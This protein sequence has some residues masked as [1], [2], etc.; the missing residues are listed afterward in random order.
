MINENQRYVTGELKSAFYSQPNQ[1]GATGL[2]SKSSSIGS[3]ISL[4][5]ATTKGSGLGPELLSIQNTKTFAQEAAP[6]A[7]S[8]SPPQRPASSSSHDSSPAGA[9]GRNIKQG[10]TTWAG[11]GSTPPEGSKVQP[12]PPLPMHSKSPSPLLQ[13]NARMTPP[14]PQNIDEFGAVLSSEMAEKVLGDLDFEENLEAQAKQLAAATVA[15]GLQRDFEGVRGRQVSPYM[16]ASGAL[17]PP[18]NGIYDAYIRS[19]THSIA[20][21]HL[22]Q[23]GSEIFSAPVKNE[24]KSTP[25]AADT[26]E[27]L[28]NDELALMNAVPQ[29]EPIEGGQQCH[30][31]GI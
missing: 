24:R 11:W 12:P 6:T 9:G 16:V 19:P 14:P 1:A 3:T 5:A 2:G 18:G 27:D 15:S 20:Q 28:L 21:T 4:S 13:A 8:K 7:P 23:T 25:A 29:V 30:G 22:Q 17:P 26:W 10:P 31:L